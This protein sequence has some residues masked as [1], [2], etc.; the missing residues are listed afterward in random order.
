MHVRVLYRDTNLLC[1]IKPVGIP[2]ESE[3]LPDLLTGQE[4]LKEIYPVQRLDQTVGGVILYALDKKSAAVLTGMLASGTVTKEYLAVVSGEPEGEEGICTDLLFHDQR[5]N[6]TYIVSRKRKG[7]RE[8]NLAWIRQDTADY[9][10]EKLSLL[11]VALHT[12]RSHQIRIQ[13]ASR[14]LP[15]VGD[16]KYGSRIK[17]AS[18][19]L[20]SHRLT[21]RHPVTGEILDFTA[22]PPAHFPWNL[23]DSI[24]SP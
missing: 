17:G 14:R 24:H 2:S 15:L 1:C 5:K 21:L 3:G 9:D 23:F 16:G 7:V 18:V 4:N 22:V 20:W 10:G 8:A 11:R 12:G 19:A 6:K 13:L